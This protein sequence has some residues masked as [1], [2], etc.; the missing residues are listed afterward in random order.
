M[1]LFS[2][3]NHLFLSLFLFSLTFLVVS[4]S[5][6]KE[7]SAAKK[8]DETYQS[9]IDFFEEIYT[10]M[11]E[12][13]YEVIPRSEFDSFKERFKTKIYSQLNDTGKSSDFIRWR[14]A[15]FLVDH[16]KTKEDVFSAFY[17]PKPAKEYEETVLGKRIDLGI[18]GNRIDIGFHVTHVEPR[19]DAYNKGLRNN[20]LLLMINEQKTIDLTDEDIIELLNPLE[21]AKT[22]LVYKSFADRKDRSI[23]VLSQEYFKQ[24]VFD[25]PLNIPNIYCLKIERFNRKT[26]EDV[27]RFISFYKKQEEMKGLIIDLRDNP[28]GPPLAAREIAS[29]FLPG[30]DEFTYFEKKGETMGTLDVPTI[31]DELKYDGPIVILVNEKS[32]SASELFSGVLQRR[33][34]GILMGTNSAGQVML[35]SMFHFD[36]ESMVLLITA[37]GRHPDGTPF[38][39]SGLTPDRLVEEGDQDN[40]LKYAA[41]YLYYKNQNNSPSTL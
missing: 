33:G 38:S 41:Q 28:G 21:E 34:R 7:E 27:F 20:D 32:G 4:Q 37:R 5:F 26:G 11:N 15:A 12:H 31:P 23:E 29:L 8:M 22:T 35:K 14:S 24:T 25:V 40:I 2:K 6:S 19:S 13:Y 1:S 36:D 30:G 39:F 16:L 17:P 9:Y 10:T 3:K 18:D